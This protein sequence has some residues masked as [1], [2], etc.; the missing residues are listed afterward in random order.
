MPR[1]SLKD[2]L[3][4][5]EV[6]EL[7]GMLGNQS[8]MSGLRKVWAEANSYWL[9]QLKLAAL[10]PTKNFG[11]IVECAARAEAAEKSESIIVEALKG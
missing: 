11:L 10:S 4:T 5:Q 6:T 7:R 9:G 1:P 8:L 2:Q 3:T